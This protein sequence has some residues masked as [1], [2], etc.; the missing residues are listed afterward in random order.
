MP[1][2]VSDFNFAFSSV[3]T[4]GIEGHLFR[5]KLEQKTLDAQ[6]ILFKSTEFEPTKVLGVL[7]NGIAL[8]VYW[9]RGRNEKIHLAGILKIL[10]NY[11]SLSPIKD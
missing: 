7:R 10:L 8:S 11:F 3:S 4:C 1:D 2:E 6:S 9:H 5:G